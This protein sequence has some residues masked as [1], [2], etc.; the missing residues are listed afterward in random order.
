MKI[1]VSQISPEGMALEEQ[2]PC[3]ELDLETEVIKFRTPLVIQA[4][5]FR[6][7]NAVTV[8][9][10]LKLSGVATCGRCLAEFEAD[11]DKDLRLNY[12]VQKS[13]EVID[14]SPDIRE[15]IIL[16][17]PMKLLCSPRCKGLCPACGK[18]LN[19]GPCSC[20]AKQKQERS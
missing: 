15:E 13:D 10:A 8:E 17:Y 11:F 3:S 12:G 4:R 7:T 9:L 18:N 6:I 20:K 19:E 14:L 1:R 5:I 2:V 16:G